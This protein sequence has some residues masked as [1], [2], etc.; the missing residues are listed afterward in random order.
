[1]WLMDGGDV[2]LFPGTIY[3]PGNYAC[4]LEESSRGSKQDE[5]VVHSSVA[6]KTDLSFTAEVLTWG[7]ALK[8]A[9]FC[10]TQNWKLPGCN[11]RPGVRLMS[12]FDDKQ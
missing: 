12:Q 10:L 4:H 6:V 8:V 7:L 5:C 11:F 2:G 9:S 3:G 1:M